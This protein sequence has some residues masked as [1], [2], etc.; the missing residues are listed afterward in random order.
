MSRTGSV[1]TLVV[2]PAGDPDRAE[3]W[4]RSVLPFVAFRV[5]A[6]TATAAARLAADDIDAVLV[7]ATTAQREAAERL[8]RL[9]PLVRDRPLVVLVPPEAGDVL[10]PFSALAGR[11]DFR[12]VADGGAVELCRALREI[13][14]EC[15]RVEQRRSRDR[16]EPLTG[17]PSRDAF[18]EAV[19][20][21]LDAGDGTAAMAVVDVDGLAGINQLL[22]RDVADHVLTL[23]AERLT[24]ALTDGDLA[25]AVGGGRL[26][27]WSPIA[28][29]PE[30]ALVRIR[31]VLQAI[32]RPFAVAGER[33]Q[34]T[35][36]AGLAFHP[37]DAV[38]FE[39]LIA[40]AEAA[41]YRAKA[42]GPG[43]YRLHQPLAVG[44]APGELKKRAVV[45]RELDREG[46]ELVFEP[47]LDL[48]TER[49]RAARLHLR[50][51]AADALLRLAGD[52]IDDLALPVI[53]WMLEA[54]GRQ[55]AG[56]LAHEVPLV[57]LVVDLPIALVRRSDVVE[58]IR[59]RLQG[60]GCHPAWFEVAVGGEP[61]G[62][63]AGDTAVAEHLQALRDLGLRV[64]LAGCGGPRSSLGALRHLPA[65]A[66]ELAGDLVQGQRERA[67]DVTILKALVGLG[68]G[69]GLDVGAAG[70]DRPGLARQLK[71]L[72]CDWASGSWV[73]APMP[74]SMFSDWLSGGGTLMIAAS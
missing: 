24:G 29:A 60:A 28:T 14:S 26:L 49:P 55:M 38:G 36:S 17:L 69:L 68:L 7:D 10:A 13:V 5:A 19:Q 4:N 66:L 73:G 20:P 34:L 27:V 6:D 54:A 72:G 42:Q 74:A 58:M 59:R 15:R 64:T 65:D 62:V 23:V 41:M 31:G 44:A 70:V 71:E 21:R 50:T 25:G 61:L 56:W 12:L 9:A 57:P 47:Q 18:R 32:A 30:A 63:D 53:R 40:R 45:R 67:G 48:R 33:L 43:G 1:K 16:L 11:I 37:A 2:A 35:A 8:E 3:R 39:T 51:R 22:G 46:L 52:E